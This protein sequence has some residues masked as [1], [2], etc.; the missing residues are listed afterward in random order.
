MPGWVWTLQQRGHIVVEL[1]GISYWESSKLLPCHTT[2]DRHDDDDKEYLSQKRERFKIRLHVCFEFQWATITIVSYVFYECS[3][4]KKISGPEKLELR[5]S[6]RFIFR[7]NFRS[8]ILRLSTESQSISISSYA[9]L[10]KNCKAVCTLLEN[11]ERSFHQGFF[12]HQLSDSL[13]RKK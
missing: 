8:T 5:V 1:G 3:A 4:M 9:I 2:R 6:Y 12:Y 11:N 7:H 13:W 10:C